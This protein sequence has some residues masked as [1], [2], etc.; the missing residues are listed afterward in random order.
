MAV[1]IALDVHKA[2]LYMWQDSAEEAYLK[3]IN[4]DQNATYTP[5]PHL[6][7]YKTN[8]RENL[9]YKLTIYS[10]RPLAKKI[11]I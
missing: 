5:Q 11:I 2:D 4:K 10:K 9:A 7:I 3:I 1:K 6:V 8:D